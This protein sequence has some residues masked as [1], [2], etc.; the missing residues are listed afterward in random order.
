MVL[1]YNGKLTRR[2]IADIHASWHNN[3]GTIDEHF[4]YDD[5]EKSRRVWQISKQ[6]DGRYVGTAG[7]VIGEAEGRASGAA[8]YWRYVLQINVDNAPMQVTLDDWM[9]LIDDRHLLNKS[10]IIKYGIKVGEVVL[11]IA[12]Q[13]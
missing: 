5:G 6:P 13:P 11:S 12:K 2:F 3:I 8:F 1:D 9:Y 7:D 10:S 4:V